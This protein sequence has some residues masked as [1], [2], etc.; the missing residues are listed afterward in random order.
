MRQREFDHQPSYYPHISVNEE[1]I[2]S[3]WHQ[4][5]NNFQ[6]CMMVYHNNKTIFVKSFQIIFP[7]N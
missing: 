2:Y 5:H 4:R 6:S 7:T 1:R 3:I